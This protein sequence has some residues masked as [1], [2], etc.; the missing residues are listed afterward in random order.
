MA[1]T[2]VSPLAAQ[3]ADSTCSC[4]A[5]H[6]HTHT[7]CLGFWSRPLLFFFFFASKAKNGRKTG[8]RQCEESGTLSQDYIASSDN[9][10][11][12]F[13]IWEWIYY[14]ATSQP[15]MCV[16]GSDCLSKANVEHVGVS[17]HYRVRPGLSFFFFW[18]MRVFERVVAQTEK[19]GNVLNGWRM[20]VNTRNNKYKKRKEKHFSFLSTSCYGLG[21][22][23]KNLRPKE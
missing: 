1:R 9:F 6:T 8:E 2:R 18:N 22:K 10:K 4:A 5:S 14:E 20:R 15:I 17:H 21:K 3:G 23:K 7:N 19:L 11:T 13:Q 12:S 16:T